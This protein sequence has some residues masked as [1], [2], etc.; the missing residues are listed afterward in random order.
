MKWWMNVWETETQ[1]LKRE[2]FEEIWDKIN[3]KIIEKSSWYFVYNWPEKLQKERWYRWQIRQNYW[4]NY[5]SWE[6]ILNP[7]ELIEYKW[8]SE[9]NI[10]DYLKACW[11]PDIEINRFLDD[12]NKFKLIKS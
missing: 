1:T 11:F 3:Y 12:F 2:I 9:N 5:I 10:T 7:D 6:V 4:V 8:V